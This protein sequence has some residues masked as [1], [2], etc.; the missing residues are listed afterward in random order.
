MLTDYES[1]RKSTRN[2]RWKSVRKDLKT[3]SKIKGLT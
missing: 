1:A 3:A 2:F